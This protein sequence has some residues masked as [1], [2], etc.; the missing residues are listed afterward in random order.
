MAALLLIVT[1]FFWGT[2]FHATA[3]G[4]E[5]TSPLMLAALRAAPAAVL[6]VAAVPI[7]RRRPLPRHLWPWAAGTGLLMV[8]LSLEGI[9]E[10]TARA[11]AGNAAVLINTTPL[12][13]LVLSRIFL[14]ERSPWPAV[15]G[16]LMGFVGVVVMVWSQLGGIDDTGNF[17]LGMGLALAAAVGWAI[18]LL[19]LKRLF[20]RDPSIDLVSLT[21]VQYAVGGTAL[22]ALAFG[23]KGTAGT[24]WSSRDLWLAIAWISI[25][26]SVIASLTYFGALKRMP[27]TTVSAW[28]FLAPVVAVVVEIVYG[29]AP[30]PTVLAGMGLAIAG[31]TVV[32]L[33]PQL[34][35]RV[36]RKEGGSRWSFSA[37]A[38]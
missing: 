12:F 7:L 34:D 13:V 3:I 32:N 28:Q 16:L 35:A 11:G 25:G 31:V 2:A 24:D 30:S 38:R 9:S 15:L 4:A 21:A 26:S 8:T 37:K 36:G 5:Y 33:A 22:V 1:M 29:N 18:A 17:M 23:L 10:S 20:D 19:F 14:R 27:A 6:L